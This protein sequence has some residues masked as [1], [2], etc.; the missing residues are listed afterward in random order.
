[1]KKLVTAALTA[2][3]A[4]AMTAVAISQT[5]SRT[6]TM[7]AKVTPTDAGTKKKPKSA[8]ASVS[9]T[10]PEGENSNVDKFTFQFP[11]TLKVSTKGFKR[12]TVSDVAEN[13]NVPPDKCKK[14]QVGSGAAVGHL[15]SRT[16]SEIPL[17]VRLYALD[18]D[19]LLV[20]V[21]D[22]ANPDNPGSLV[23]RAFTAEISA[24]ADADFGQQIQSD[25]PAD[26][27]NVG[28]PVILESLSLKIGKQIK[29]GKKRYR[30]LSS[31]G[32]P[33]N[34][35]WLLGSVLEYNLP[36]GAADTAARATTAC[37][38]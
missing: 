10:T 27:E 5:S 31:R 11:N 22:V 21:D 36:E 4:L 2:V 9:L 24:S 20:Y 18:S 34:G 12:C 30:I 38:K 13:G 29:R 16:A 3:L 25:I 14:A 35:Q 7:D 17:R 6:H 15:G 1:M 28:A 19:Q 33:A 37:K 8:T 26:L 32:C 23:K